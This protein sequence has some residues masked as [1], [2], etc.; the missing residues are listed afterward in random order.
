[1][2]PVALIPLELIVADPIDAESNVGVFNNVMVAPIPDADI[3]K[4]SLL[5]KLISWILFAVPTTD[6]SS[7]TVIP[8]IP[9]P[10]PP[11]PP[12]AV[13]VAIPPLAV[14]VP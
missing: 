4:L 12:E 8:L 6:P 3:V 2:I 10:P 5:I 7:L 14:A 1:M 9:S 11:P 13:I